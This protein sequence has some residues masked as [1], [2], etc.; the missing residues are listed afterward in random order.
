MSHIELVR[1][2]SRLVEVVDC[3]SSAQRVAVDIES[4]GFFRY[5]E[6]ICLVQLSSGDTA[7][8]VDPLAIEDLRPLGELLGDLSVEK[9][10]HAGDYDLRSFDRDWGFRLNNIFD[11]GI[12]ASLIGSQQLSLQAVVEE[13][14]GVKLEKHRNLQR[15]DWTK[16]PLSPEAVKYAA[17][18]VL[19]LL[20]VREEL[21]ARL[22]SLIHI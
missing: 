1:S 3:I 15:S 16:R 17:S 21:S 5:H 4:N 11:T 22:L 20:K 19:H 6:R 8:L 2:E 13:Y 18:D 7:F 12:A 9:V 14:A 10:F